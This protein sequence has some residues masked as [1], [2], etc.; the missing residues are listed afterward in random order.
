MISFNFYGVGNEMFNSPSFW[1]LLL[2]VPC[3]SGL[4]ELTVQLVGPAASS[5]LPCCCLVLSM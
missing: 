4:L 3:F 5:P 1:W 2:L